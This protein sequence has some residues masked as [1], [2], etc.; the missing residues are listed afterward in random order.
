MFPDYLLTLEKVSCSKIFTEMGHNLYYILLSVL[1]L[2][3]EHYLLAIANF[4]NE[5]GLNVCWF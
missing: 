5:T 1:K 3:Y 2:H 4:T